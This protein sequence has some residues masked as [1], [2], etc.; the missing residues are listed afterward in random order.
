MPDIEALAFETEEFVR[1]PYSQYYYIP[2]SVVPKRERPQWRFTAL[3]LFKQINHAVTIEANVARAAA[4]LEKLYVML[5]YSC[6]YIL[7]SG[8]DSFQSVGIAQEDFFQLCYSSNDVMKP[9]K[10]LFG[11]ASNWL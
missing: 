11:T 10:N 6:R 8:Y 7:F 9:R 2:N 1:N 3:R 5:C 4:L